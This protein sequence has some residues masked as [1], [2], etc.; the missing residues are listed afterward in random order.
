M[1]VLVISCGPGLDEVKSEYGHSYQWVQD[2]CNL[3]NVHFSQSNAYKGDLPKIEDGDGW[4][5]TGSAKSVYEDLD[6]IVELEMLI[7]RAYEFQKPILGICFGHQIIAQALGG[8]VEKNK[9]GWE[10]GSSKIDINNQ[11][12]LSKIFKDVSLDDYFYMSHQDTVSKLPNHSQELAFNEMGNQAYS[13]GNFI[14]GVQFHPEFSHAVAEKY[15]LIRYQKGILK[16]KPMVF[17]SQTSY[18]VI[19]NFIKILQESV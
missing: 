5:I 2:R 6:W 7:K 1:E 12:N 16:N 4:I 8:L 19:N 17:K 3:E 14:Y 10:L 15:A 11:G 13:I 18:N 9:K